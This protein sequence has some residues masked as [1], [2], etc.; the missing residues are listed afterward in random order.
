MLQERIK[1]ILTYLVKKMLFHPDK[2]ITEDTIVEELLEKGFDIEEI[3]EALDMLSEIETIEAH[4]SDLP[5]S[6]ESIRVLD[7]YERH[8]LDLEA[9]GV[10]ATIAYYSIMTPQQL[11]ELIDRAM[12]LSARSIGKDEIIGQAVAMISE[13]QGIL[14]ASYLLSFLN[15]RGQ[16]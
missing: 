6:S 4:F 12:S 10:I 16:N 13:E 9:Q 11:D 5:A 2:L 15:S 3:E 8:R 1:D 14:S 7:D